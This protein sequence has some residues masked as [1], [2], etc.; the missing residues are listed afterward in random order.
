MNPTSD[1]LHPG[2]LPEA[3]DGPDA[4]APESAFTEMRDR[5][6]RSQAEI[7]NVRTR[8]RRD[9]DDARQ[10]AVQKFATDVVEAAENL[11]RGLEGLPAASAHES[12]NMT[13]IRRG[14]LEIERGFIG[15]L[16]RNGVK[17]DDP[18][19]SLFDPNLHQAMSEQEAVGVKPG[20]ILQTLA[21]TWTL[22]GRLLRPAMVI[23]AKA[24][25][26]PPPATPRRPAH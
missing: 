21:P 20:T 18:A 23:V 11:H 2:N 24:A 10:F 1:P 6:M 14:L 3:D 7:A 25:S 13:G 15:V 22:N 5:W 9:V 17:R 16:E 19:G 26:A 4:A 8:A 12:E